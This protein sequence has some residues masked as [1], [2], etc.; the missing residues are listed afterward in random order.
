M[1][2]FTFGLFILSIDFCV[3]FGYYHTGLITVALWYSLKSVW[4]LQLCSSL[5]RLLWLFQVFHTYI[6]SKIVFVL[7]LKPFT[8]DWDSNQAKT[9]LG[10]W[11]YMA[12]T[13][14]Q[15]K[16]RLGLE[17]TWLGLEPSQN[18]AWD[19]NPRG[20]DSN[21]AKTH[22]SWFLDLMKLRF[23]MSHCRTNSVRDKMIGKKWIYSDTERSTLCRQSVGHYRGWV[24]PWTV[25]GLV[26]IGWVI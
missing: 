16:P 13:Q 9:L 19:L 15:P 10:T 3:F 18:P 26:L 14:T 21:P 25:A 24:Q 5:P 6:Q 11:T 12:G 7:V 22:S 20:W 23:V 17:S 2:G 8:T 4:Y 1:H